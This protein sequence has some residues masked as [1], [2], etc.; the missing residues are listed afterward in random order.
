MK[1]HREL[2]SLDFLGAFQSKAVGRHQVVGARLVVVILILGE[3]GCPR[4]ILA[5][6]LSLL[7]LNIGDLRFR[8][9]SVL[10]ISLEFTHLVFRDGLLGLQVLAIVVS[11][12]LA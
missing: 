1:V 10:L 6:L 4:S 5:G 3:P 8:P 7:N 12:P 2:C 11:S 9:A